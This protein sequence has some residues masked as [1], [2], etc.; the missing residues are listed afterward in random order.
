ML[1]RHHQTPPPHRGLRR[2]QIQTHP[3]YALPASGFSSNHHQVVLAKQLSLI[4]SPDALKLRE[5]SGLTPIDPDNPAL[6][7]R[8]R[9][10]AVF[11]RQRRLAEQLA[12]PAVQGADVGMIVGRDLLEIVDGRD[13]LAGYRMAFRR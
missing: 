6:V 3:G 8:E 7:D 10:P 4:R 1:S 2:L 12:A 5:K 9:Q 11:Q 13:D